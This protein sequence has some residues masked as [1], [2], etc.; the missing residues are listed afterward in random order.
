MQTHFMHGIFKPKSFMFVSFP[1]P[2]IVSTTLSIP[3]W[4][5][6]I[7]YEYDALIKNGTWD[8]VLK[9]KEGKVIGQKWVFKTKLLHDRSLDKYK[10]KVVA[11]G[12]QQ[13]KGLHYKET[14]SLVVKPITI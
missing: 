5:A 2:P 3:V 8:L 13:T 6:S 1:K 14:F 11:K 4:K 9:L 7:Q 12:F 10:S